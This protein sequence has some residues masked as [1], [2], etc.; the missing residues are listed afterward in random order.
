[1]S[2]KLTTLL[3]ASTA[4]FLVAGPALAQTVDDIDFGNDTSIWANDGSCDDPRFEGEGMTALLEEENVGADA[5]D[6]E[7]LFIIGEVTLADTDAAVDAAATA[8]AE[9]DTEAGTDTDDA[10]DVDM[11]VTNEESDADLDEAEARTAEDLLS[12]DM[13]PEEADD[14]RVDL[15][16]AETPDELPDTSVAEEADDAKTALTESEPD[17]MVDEALEDGADDTAATDDE[18]PAIDFG[19]DESKFALDGECDDARFIGEAMTNTDL[20]AKDIRQDASDCRAGV[21]AGLLRLRGPGDPSVASVLGESE[22]E[23]AEDANEADKAALEDTKAEAETKA[24]TSDDIEQP[25]S[26]G[27]MFNGIDFGDDSSKWAKDGECDDP[28]FTGKGMTETSLL[29]D[30]AY[31]DATDCLAAWK[32]GELRLARN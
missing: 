23:I 12:E 26:T 1:M 22:T 15:D 7:A 29:A 4:M 3:A 13:L 28:R 14:S 9:L 20:I 19:D 31:H 6:C 18:P 25:A 21:E 2:C 17:A 5:A 10:D 16:E 24:P 11:A 27:L 30:D 8:D 32:T